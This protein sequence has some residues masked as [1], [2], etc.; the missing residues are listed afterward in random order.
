MICSAPL[1]APFVKTCAKSYLAKNVYTGFSL[2]AKLFMNGYLFSTLWLWHEDYILLGK[3]EV[4]ITYVLISYYQM[5][6]SSYPFQFINSV[7]KQGN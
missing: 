1:K 7:M 3:E 6:F 2:T 4:E 5:L